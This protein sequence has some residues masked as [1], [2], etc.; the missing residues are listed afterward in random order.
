MDFYYL[1]N[2]YK[3]IHTA[4]FEL[5]NCMVFGLFKDETDAGLFQKR[6]ERVAKIMNKVYRKRRSVRS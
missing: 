1:P 4:C 2:E 3:A 5:F 6:F